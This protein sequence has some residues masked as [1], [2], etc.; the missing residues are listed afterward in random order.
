MQGVFVD[1]SCSSVRFRRTRNGNCTG[2][3]KYLA[4]GLVAML[5]LELQ[6]LRLLR[7]DL[8]GQDALQGGQRPLATGKAAEGALRPKRHGQPGRRA[9]VGE[10][11][12]RDVTIY[13]LS[14]APR[15]DPYDTRRPS[16]RQGVL[17]NG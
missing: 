6:E 5:L 10:T 7:G 3:P 2:R 1:A 15:T 8:L 12:W 16:R 17:C 4:D 11:G 13:A 9:P 14:R